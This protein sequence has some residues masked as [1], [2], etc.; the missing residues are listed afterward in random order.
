VLQKPF[1][2]DELLDRIR[3]ALRSRAA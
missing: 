1:T 2:P 3:D